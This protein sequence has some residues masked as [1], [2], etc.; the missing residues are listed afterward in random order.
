M[1]DG[2]NE[3]SDDGLKGWAI[4]LIVIAILVVLGVVFF[5]LVR[6][7]ICCQKQRVT[8]KGGKQ[9]KYEMH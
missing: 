6:A 5:I 2:F 7:G 9:K 1:F 3:G 4:A 8:G